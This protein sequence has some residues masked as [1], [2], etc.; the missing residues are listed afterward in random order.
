MNLTRYKLLG[1][2]LTLTMFIVLTPM[3]FAEDHDTSQ[4][5]PT[6]VESPTLVP[7]LI[8]TYFGGSGDDYSYS[9]VHDSVG[10]VIVVGD[11]DSTDFAVTAN[12][13]QPANAGGFDIIVAKFNP[14]LD[15]ILAATY[16]G[17]SGGDEFA[18]MTID[19]LGN[20]YVA[21]RTTST[22]FPGTAGGAQTSYGGGTHDSAV[23]KLNANLDTLTQ[24]TYLGGSG[25]D[26]G[27]ELALDSSNNIFV[28]GRTTSVNFPGTAG[29]AQESN[30]GSTDLIISKLNNGLTTI[31]QSTYLGTTSGEIG[32]ALAID[33]SDNIFVTGRTNGASFPGVTGGAQTT[34]AGGVDVIISKLNNNLTTI[35]QS[36]YL[37]GTLDDITRG[38]G[39]DSSDNIFVIGRTTSTDIPGIVGGAQPVIAGSNDVFIS[40][41]NNNLT[42]LTQSTY[43]G[44]TSNEDVAHGFVIEFDG[45]A[46]GDNLYL[47]GDTTST[48]FPGTANGVQ[49]SNAG[50]ADIFISKLNNG[51]TT[52]DQSTYLGGTSND[53]EIGGIA[54]NGDSLY[55][56]FD[57]KSTDIPNTA[58]G[59]QPSN[60]GGTD[61]F[62]YKMP[63]NLLLPI[64]VGPVPVTWTNDVGVTVNGNSMTSVAPKGWGNAGASSV[65]SAASGDVY[66][67][68]TVVS[69]SNYH[70]GLSNGDADQ[71]TEDI[72][73]ALQVLPN[74]GNV[75]VHEYGVFQAKIAN[76]ITDDIL[77]MA[78]EGTD[79]VFYKNDTEKHRFANVINQTSSYPLLVDA[80]IKKPGHSINDVQFYTGP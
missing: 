48:D 14:S 58:N 17:G 51:L 36:T 72:N 6:N 23:F 46:N 3:S 73:F 34:I 11:T 80:A 77:K 27:M 49:P 56:S 40:K 60:A 22:D 19:S 21:T 41:L 37:G 7:E 53:D 38:M 78:V 61:L 69:G 79:V 71:D 18:D 59:V 35:T 76:V 5:I 65:Q 63:S 4:N 25:I 47:G 26:I 50:G 54:I 33:S 16:V 10:N 29:G 67:T 45:L 44:G 13:T 55:V 68:V 28:T 57:T 9:I 2:T 74:S 24:S 1:I 12:A 31:T 75:Y 43:L 15:T 8:S 32:A 52:L 20:I 30:A 62:I 39:I 42:T 70:I 64:P 66:L